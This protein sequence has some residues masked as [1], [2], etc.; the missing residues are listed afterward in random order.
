MNS[1][2]FAQRIPSKVENIRY[3][4]TFGKES[5]GTWGDDDHL[6][7]FF[8]I[9]PP[10]Y[11]KPIYIRVFDPNVGGNLDEVNGNFNTKTK[12]SVYGGKGAHSAYSSRKSK[13][14]QTQNSGNLLASKTFGDEPSYDKKWYTFGPFNPYE[15][16][17]IQELGGY[18]FKITAEGLTGDDGNLYYYY[19]S[20]DANFNTYVEGSRAF[21]YEYCVRG[22]KEKGSILHFYPFIPEGITRVTQHNFDYDND[23]RIFLYSVRKNRH[24][25][26]VSGEGNWVSSSHSILKEEQNTSMDIQIVSRGVP[27]N[28]F[29]FYITDQHGKHLPLYSSPIGGIPK[30]RYNIQIFYHNKP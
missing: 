26:R 2:L 12:F 21:T 25:V 20:E 10:T 23:G 17:N 11:Q 19:I 15:G 7:T 22:N 13:L 28:N 4:T 16:E 14:K 1:Q 27:V 24:A 9:I 6:Q 30:Y 3:L 18:V 8:V 5:I 29:V